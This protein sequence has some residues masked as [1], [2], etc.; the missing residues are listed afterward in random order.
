MKTLMLISNRSPIEEG[1]RAEKI[2]AQIRLLNDQGWDVTVAETKTSVTNIP[3]AVFRCWRHA[4][5]HD[6]DAYLSISNPPHLQL[7]GLGLNFLLNTPWVAYFRDPMVTIP[8]IDSGTFSYKIRRIIEGSVVRHANKV[9]WMDGIQVQKKYFTETYPDVPEDRF[10]ELPF[11]GFE[12]EKFESAE[13]VEYDMFTIT[14]AGSFYEGWIEPYNFLDGIEKYVEEYGEDIRVQFYGDWNKDYQEAIE[15]RG[16][17]DVVET[18]EFVP[19]DEIIPVLKGSDIV[20]HI[21]GNDPRNKLNIPS[22]IWDYIGSSTPILAIADPSFDVAKFIENEGL[23]VCLSPEDTAG[24]SEYINSVRNGGE[25][26]NIGSDL[27]QKF[28]RQ[29]N[30]EELANVLDS[31]EERSTETCNT[32]DT[33]RRHND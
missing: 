25:T 2:D 27:F 29:R 21:G 5:N 4:R 23:G 13:S 18:H 8:D 30:I 14:Y 7:V 16:L 10:Y 11:L 6:V 33:V 28:S 32:S 24:I 9:V 1:G 15:N 20:V 26:I 17:R 22:K 12:S 3:L 31:L 19:H